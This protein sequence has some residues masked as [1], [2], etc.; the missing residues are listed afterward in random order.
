MFAQLQL[1]AQ[2]SV[3]ANEDLDNVY[4]LKLFDTMVL[5]PSIN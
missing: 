3:R 4:L 1:Q 2:R 5:R